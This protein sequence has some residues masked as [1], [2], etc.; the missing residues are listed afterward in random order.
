VIRQRATTGGLVSA[1]RI[2]QHRI[3][4][5]KIGPMPRRALAALHEYGL[6]DEEIARYLGLTCSSLR[7][8][9]R[10]LGVGPDTLRGGS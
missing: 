1:T 2:E 10:T 8:L 6:D 4:L 5:T 9:E 3:I 7:R